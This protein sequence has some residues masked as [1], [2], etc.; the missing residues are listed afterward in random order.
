[1]N[2][3]NVG[4]VILLVVGIVVLSN[5][6]MFAMVRGS[7]GVRLDWLKNLRQSFGEPLEGGDDALSELHKRVERLSHRD[8]D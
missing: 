5:L 1:M 2:S 8:E 4:L 6:A 7:R 3:D